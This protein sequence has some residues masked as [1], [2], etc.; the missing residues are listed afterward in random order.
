MEKTVLAVDDSKPDAQA[1]FKAACARANQG[2]IEPLTRNGLLMA[3]AGQKYAP[4]EGRQVREK[5]QKRLRGKELHVEYVGPDAEHKGH[6]A[7]G[8]LIATNVIEVQFDDVAHKHAYGWH[9]YNA[10]H[11]AIRTDV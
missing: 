5:R 4:H 8:R 9:P 11:W 3:L 1:A 10:A 6:T 7:L 2:R